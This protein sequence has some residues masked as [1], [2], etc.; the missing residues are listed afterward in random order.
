MKK[1]KRNF[2]WERRRNELKLTAHAT[3]DTR[4]KANHV[5]YCFV[6]FT[7]VVVSAAFVI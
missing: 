1:E 3:N 7:V 6:Y 4:Q 5:K 2:K